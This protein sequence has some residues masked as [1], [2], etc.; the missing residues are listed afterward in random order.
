[1]TFLI[2]KLLDATMGLRVKEDEEEIGLD[3]SQHGE[4]GY[5]L[6]GSR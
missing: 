5:I 2:L 3:E 1:V 6:E 4:R